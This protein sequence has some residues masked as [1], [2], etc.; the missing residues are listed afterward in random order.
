MTWSYHEPV[1]NISTLQLFA[2]H[3]IIIY[4]FF[5]AVWWY[6]ELKLGV[7]Y[8]TTGGKIYW[9]VQAHRRYACHPSPSVQKGYYPSPPSPEVGTLLGKSWMRHCCWNIVWVTDP[10]VGGG[11]F[12]RAKPPLFPSTDYLFG[13]FTNFLRLK[14]MYEISR[15]I[16][17]CNISCGKVMFLQLSV[18][19]FTGR[20]VWQGRAWQQKRTL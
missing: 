10:G 9:S 18:I 15:I 16:T 1:Y 6:R 12:K 5:T 7:R 14:K 3:E 4:N 2:C 13:S 8:T 17:V 19:L 20:H 11:G